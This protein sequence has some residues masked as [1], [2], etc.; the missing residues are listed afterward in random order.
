M[1]RAVDRV[2]QTRKNALARLGHHLGDAVGEAQRNQSIPLAP[3]E[4][5]R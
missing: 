1:V 5:R 3:D 2:A 4:G